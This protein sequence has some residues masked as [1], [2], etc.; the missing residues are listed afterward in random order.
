MFSKR[1]IAL[2]VGVI[3]VL[4]I[5]IL[6][7]TSFVLADS[8]RKPER[9][10]G[11][12]AVELTL[13]TGP[14]NGGLVTFFADGNVVADETGEGRSSGHGIWVMDKQGQVHFTAV[15]LLW[16]PAD[17]T[18][19]GRFVISQTLNWDAANGTWSGPS[20]VTSYNAVGGVDFTGTVPAKFTRIQMAPAP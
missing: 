9:L 2:Y 10:V 4:V 16:N 14:L 20:T 3:L 13:P 5:G 6:A 1:R 15:E 12:W 18:Y 8:N 11:A 17:D 19:A 7:I